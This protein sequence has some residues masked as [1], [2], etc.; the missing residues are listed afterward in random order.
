MAG[1]IK[2]ARKGLRPGSSA[3]SQPVTQQEGS[4]PSPKP[5]TSGTAR[6]ASTWK[7]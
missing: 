1:S 6:P 3:Q 4:G 5:M 2:Q 7:K